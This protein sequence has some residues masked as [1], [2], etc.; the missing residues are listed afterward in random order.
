MEYL[1]Q[2]FKKSDVIQNLKN[3]QGMNY[4]SKLFTQ[5]KAYVE[6]QA[7]SQWDKTLDFDKN[8]AKYKSEF[9]IDFPKEKL[10]KIE[11][12]RQ[13]QPYLFQ[14]LMATASL[15]SLLKETQTDL[16]YDQNVKLVARYQEWLNL[17]A[18]Q[19]EKNGLI[20]P[21]SAKNMRF[22][23]NFLEADFELDRLSFL[24]NTAEQ[25]IGLVQLRQER[26][27]IMEISDDPI[28]NVLYRL[29]KELYGYT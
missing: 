11:K 7:Q 14:E 2:E 9:F 24:G 5:S 21:D 16:N 27:A 10:E 1:S 17:T 28:Q 15:S 29:A 3:G 20:I 18:L 4:I 13:E 25:V 26:N 23:E 6:I 22:I 19:S 12:L 8:L